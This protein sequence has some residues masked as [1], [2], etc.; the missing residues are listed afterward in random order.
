MRVFDGTEYRDATPEEI[1]AWEAAASQPE[2]MPSPQEQAMILARTLAASYTGLSDTV[3]LSR[4]RIRA[5]KTRGPAGM[6]QRGLALVRI[7]YG[8][9]SW[10]KGKGRAAVYIYV[11]PVCKAA[12]SAGNVPS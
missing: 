12:A 3:A 8:Q 5:N 2:P 6:F 10:K 11:Q 7:S 9:I 4:Q 1:S